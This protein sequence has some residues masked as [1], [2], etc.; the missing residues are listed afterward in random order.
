MTKGEFY[1]YMHD[2]NIEA[3]EYAKDK[4]EFKDIM[5]NAYAIGA[6]NMLKKFLNN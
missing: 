5:E 4:G 2:I 6:Y 1:K 3:Y